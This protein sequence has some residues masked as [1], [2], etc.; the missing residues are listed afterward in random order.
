MNN[1]SIMYSQKKIRTL[2]TPY[3]SDVSILVDKSSSMYE[4]NNYYLQEHIINVIEELRFINMKNTHASISLSLTSFNNTVYKYFINEN[5][6][7]METPSI[8]DLELLLTSR[9]QTKLHDS[10]YQEI[11]NQKERIRCYK[12]NLPNELK[13]LDLNIKR[14]LYVITDGIDN[15]SITSRKKLREKLIEEQG[16]GLIIIFVIINFDEIYR[17]PSY[18]GVS[19]KHFLVLTKNNLKC[20]NKTETLLRNIACGL[21]DLN[22]SDYNLSLIINESK[23]KIYYPFR[24]RPIFDEILSV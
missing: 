6:K 4:I 19:E 13:R 9:G 17:N 5:V 7:F 12:N 20:F 16:K 8:N 2:S 10:L 14:V 11:S 21:Y 3:H 24:R 22:K 18:F 15:K 1:N 23:D